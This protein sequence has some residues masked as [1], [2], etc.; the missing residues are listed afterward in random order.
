MIATEPTCQNIGQYIF[1]T[2][3]MFDAVHKR[4]K[5]QSPSPNLQDSM[6]SELTFNSLWLKHEEEV[7]VI[8]EDHRRNVRNEQIV[9]FAEGLDD[10]KSLTFV[11]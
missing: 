2:T 9:Q 7:S 8:R 4:V 10:S 5:K 6:A 1:S 3:D 11:S